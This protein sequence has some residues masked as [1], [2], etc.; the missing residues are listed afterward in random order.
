MNIITV[1]LLAVGLCFDSFAV[2]L[3]C[4]VSGNGSRPKKKTLA[5]FALVLAVLQGIMP[6][7]GWG[8][9]FELRPYI[10]SADHWVAFSLLSLIGIKMIRDSFSKN[11]ECG[12]GS[13]SLR[14]N[15]ILGIATSIDALIMGAAMAIVSVS[16]IPALPEFG[17]MLIA[18]LIIAAITFLSSVTGLYLGR[19]TSSKLGDG[20]GII[21]GAILI[22]IGVKILIEHL[23]V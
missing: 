9:A 6:L 4:G 16:I 19:K 7:L 20:A 22:V 1:I 17:N 23:S 3:S 12:G 5:R 13:L 18:S 2:S 21:G 14:K 15:V 11:E 10:E 8:M